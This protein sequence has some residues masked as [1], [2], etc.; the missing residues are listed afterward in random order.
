[1]CCAFWHWFLI[2]TFSLIRLKIQTHTHP[3]IAWETPR[4]YVRRASYHQVKCLKII[5]H[6]IYN[7][8]SFISFSSISGIHPLRNYNS[9]SLILRL[10]PVLCQREGVFK[11][12]YTLDRDEE[13]NWKFPF[14]SSGK[15]RAKGIKSS[16]HTG[17]NTGKV[18]ILFK[19][20]GAVRGLYTPKV[21][22]SPT[23]KTHPD[24]IP[25]I[26]RLCQENEMLRAATLDFS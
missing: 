15:G 18:S 7:F 9:D 26:F 2:R 6:Q 13:V 1:M 21:S 3:N 11:T 14:P 23:N 12:I 20:D 16:T 22:Q 10:V 25:T 5:R 24:L 4:S 19:R 8:V 17:T